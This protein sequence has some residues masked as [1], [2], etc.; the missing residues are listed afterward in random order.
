[1]SLNSTKRRE[2][3]KFGL[4]MSTVTLAVCLLTYWRGHEIAPY[5][6]G[7]LCVTFV[8]LQLWMGALSVAYRGWMRFAHAI[9]WF[10]S[11]VLLTIVY[12]VVIMPIGLIMR[13]AG[14][15]PIRIRSWNDPGS[16]W[17]DCSKDGH[18]YTRM[19]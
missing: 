5:V 15:R 1:M 10:N 6:F 4:L 17:A 3:R 13:A 18:D 14:K 7:A 2:I 8:L 12:F 16:T 9:G 11:R 19:F